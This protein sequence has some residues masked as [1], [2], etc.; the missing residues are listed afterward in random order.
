MKHIEFWNKTSSLTLPDGSVKT[1]EEIMQSYPFAR[2]DDVVLEYL[3]PGVVGAIDSLSI[4]KQVYG[5]TVQDRDAALLE[6]IEIRNRPPEPVPDPNEEL[7]AKLDYIT[8]M[9]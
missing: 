9:I 2:T 6:I 1:A 7:N 4:L 5:V 3:A 8:M